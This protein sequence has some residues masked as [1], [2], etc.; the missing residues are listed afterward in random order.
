MSQT[1]APAAHTWCKPREG[2]GGGRVGDGC[3][4]CYDGSTLTVLSNL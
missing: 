2:G 3:A 1:G 4:G